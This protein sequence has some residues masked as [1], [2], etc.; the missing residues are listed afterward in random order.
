MSNIYQ[1]EAELLEGDIKALADYKGKVMLIV[2]TASK[3]G[4][5]PQ[6]AGLE[7]LYEKYKPQG[8]EIL[9]FPC[10]QFGGQD[11]GTNKEIGAF[12]QRNYG[13]NFPMFAKV[14]V[15]GPEAH[16]I[17]RFLTREAKGILGS[18]NIKWNFTKFLVGRNGEVLGRYAPTTKPEALEADIEKALASK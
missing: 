7:K 3:C 1:F 10:N 8:L 18:Q 12:C 15:K 5:T 9:G 14:D 16:A 13:V 6:F 4:F 11:P 17:F 2:N